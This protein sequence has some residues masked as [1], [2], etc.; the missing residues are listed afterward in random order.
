MA[1]ARNVRIEGA[2]ADQDALLRE[3][4]GGLGN[5]RIEHVRLEPF[6]RIAWED[7][8]EFGTAPSPDEIEL[9][10]GVAV[11]LAS[12]ER[13]DLRTSWEFTLLGRAFCELSAQLGLTRVVW[14][15][16]GQ[17]GSAVGVPDVEPP[18]TPARDAIEV[19]VQ[20][21]AGL[22][23]ALL[24]RLEIL[25][26]LGPAPV[27][28]LAVAEPHAFLRHGLAAFVEL[29]GHGDGRYFGSFVRVLD[30]ELE[31]VWEAGHYRYGGMSGGRAD[32]A[33]CA[34][35]GW[36][37]IDDP[38]PPPCRVTARTWADANAAFRRN[39]DATTGRPLAEW[40]ALLDSEGL[41]TASDRFHRLRSEHGLGD[42]HAA[43]IVDATERP[44][45]HEE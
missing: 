18:E 37:M 36:G 23:G 26:P 29:S 10:R 35:R 14:V 24:D 3:I 4:A 42:A 6:D 13:P 11:V 32:V 40:L 1:K 31:P 33:C 15:Q 28:T 22:T 45:A 39:L 5:T 12:P 41:A 16:D 21:A 30:G 17:S 25:E 44:P 2:S 38:G 27:M 8:E 19:T 20:V 43:A 34:P 7:H 9:N